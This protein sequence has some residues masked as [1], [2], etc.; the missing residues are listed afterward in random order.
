MKKI[1]AFFS[2]FS[3]FFPHLYL[4]VTTTKRREANLFIVNFRSI[5]Y[6]MQTISGLKN[7][8]AVQ[9]IS[10]DSYIFNSKCSDRSVGS[11]T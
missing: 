4:D 2:F 8:L 6:A 11:K 7:T 3:S 10:Y 1:Q 9:C 5:L